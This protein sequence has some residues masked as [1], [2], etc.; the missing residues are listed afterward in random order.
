METEISGLTFW[1]RFSSVR[2][3]K[4]RNS[5]SAH[6]LYLVAYVNF[7]LN[8][9][10]DDDDDDDDTTTP[11][12]LLQSH[13]TLWRWMCFRSAVWHRTT[14]T[15]VNWSGDDNA[16]RCPEAV[17]T[18]H[19]SHAGGRSG[20]GEYVV[21]ADTQTASQL[22]LQL[23]ESTFP[24]LSLCLQLC[25]TETKY[26]TAITYFLFCYIYRLYFAS[27]AAR[28][29]NTTIYNLE[30][31]LAVTYLI[32]WSPVAGRTRETW[33]PLQR[34]QTHNNG[35]QRYTDL[36]STPSWEAHLRSAH[37]WSTQ[38]LHCKYTVP[39]FTS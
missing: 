19:S 2:V 28:D 12:L 4:N 5:V 17:L 10:D 30:W 39:A 14:A 34:R 18:P 20:I 13:N 9:Y 3:F 31:K 16:W 29:R 1:L 27:S 15:A 38:F 25:C 37:V 8:E 33:W 7:L 36:Y 23:C 26:L 21:Y 35:N 6:P 32:L 22:S 11:H 24:H